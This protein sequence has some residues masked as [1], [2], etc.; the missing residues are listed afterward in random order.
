M[1]VHTL[2]EPTYQPYYEVINTLFSVLDRNNAPYS[3]NSPLARSFYSI[4]QSYNK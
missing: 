3:G 4:L 2:G 1:P